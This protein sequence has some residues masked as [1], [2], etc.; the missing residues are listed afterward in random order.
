M[1]KKIHLIGVTLDFFWCENI[2]NIC[3]LTTF[4]RN[5][6]KSAI[7]F[8]PYQQNKTKPNKIIDKKNTCSRS[9]RKLL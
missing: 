2:A 1:R 8:H 3:N 7:E 5:M 4:H 9:E 6:F